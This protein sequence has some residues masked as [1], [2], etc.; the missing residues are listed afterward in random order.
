TAA[1][2]SVSEAD[3]GFTFRVT[4]TASN[5]QGTSSVTSAYTKAAA[6]VS[7]SSGWDSRAPGADPKRPTWSHGPLGVSL[8]SGNAMVT[9]P[10]PSFPTAT[11]SMGVSVTW[12]SLPEQ[13]KPTC[14][15]TPCTPPP[16]Y[17]SSARGGALGPGMT[18]SVGERA[19]RRP[20]L[21][22][23]HNDLSAQAKFNEIE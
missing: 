11:G 9:F 10:G 19:A 7:W 12:N 17:S 16:D 3:T 18:L 21:L 13:P 22:I 8:I 14:S 6:S 2:Y 20:V 5:G 15:P 23:D 1:S 4:V